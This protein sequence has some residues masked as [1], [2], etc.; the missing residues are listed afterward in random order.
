MNTQQTKLEPRVPIF[1]LWKIQTLRNTHALQSPRPDQYTQGV[2]QGSGHGTSWVLVNKIIDPNVNIKTMSIEDPSKEEPREESKDSESLAPLVYGT[3]EH[4]NLFYNLG[5]Y[6]KFLSI[7]V[8]YGT[9]KN[10]TTL[11]PNQNYLL[12]IYRTMK[13]GGEV[14]KTTATEAKS[15]MTHS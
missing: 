2:G 7:D 9:G 11:T 14:R 6:L 4:L 8:D 5:D 13:G 10:G 1:K 15:R 12:D 3:P